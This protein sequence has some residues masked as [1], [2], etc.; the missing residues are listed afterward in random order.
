MTSW[1]PAEARN[2]TGGSVIKQ[3]KKKRRGAEKV[4]AF[5]VNKPFWGLSTSH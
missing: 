3:H 4:Q 5:Q 2:S 1:G